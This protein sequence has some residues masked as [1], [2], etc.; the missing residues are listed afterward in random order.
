MISITSRSCDAIYSVRTGRRESAVMLPGKSPILLLC[1]DG[2]GSLPDG[3]YYA[4]NKLSHVSQAYLTGKADTKRYWRGPWIVGAAT[5]SI[6]LDVASTIFDARKSNPETK[7]FMVGHS[8]GGAA[9]IRAAQIM[10]LRFQMNQKR[11]RAS[12]IGNNSIEAIFLY[13]A[14]N[15]TH[16][17]SV[18]VIPP[19][20]GKC[21]HAMRDP[22]A[23]SRQSWGNCAKISTRS[24]QLVKKTFFGSHA[25]LGGTPGTGDLEPRKVEVADFTGV[26]TVKKTQWAVIEPACAKA[27]QLWMFKHM[28][29]HGVM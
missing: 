4:E 18:D 29:T 3:T 13:D 15:M 14:V 26:V 11:G 10:N 5:S 24:G 16:N 1:V 12:D 9:I 28:K 17:L 23:L 7:I 2:T 21:Y 8:R 27:A 25:A 19:N 20:V 6:A 22:V